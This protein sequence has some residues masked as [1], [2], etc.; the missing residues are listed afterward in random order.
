MSAAGDDGWTATGFEKIVGNELYKLIENAMPMNMPG[1][2]EWKNTNQDTCPEIKFELKLVNNKLG[3]AAKN[4]AFLNSF[5]SGAYWIQ[6]GNLQRS[7]NLFSLECPGRFYYLYCTMNCSVTYHGKARYVASDLITYYKTMLGVDQNH[8]FFAQLLNTA[9]WIPDAYTITVKFHSLMPNNFNAYIGYILNQFKYAS[10]TPAAV[11][12]SIVDRQRG[13]TKTL[14]GFTSTA[15]EGTGVVGTQFKSLA[16]GVKK[17]L[18]TPL[19]K[20]GIV[21]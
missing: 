8:P 3:D 14:N 2:P 5:I 21:P 10:S 1:V 16:T 17:V 7:P 12:A 6:I 20:G 19:G 11:K 4:F 9:F 13:L 18:T 15:E